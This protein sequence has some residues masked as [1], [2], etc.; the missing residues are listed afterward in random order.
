MIKEG[1]IGLQEAV[2][3]VTITSAT[4]LF[5]TSPSFLVRLV[6]TSA[7]YVTIISALTGMLGFTFIYFLLKRFP[8][9]DIV[10]AFEL[11]LG[12]FFGFILSL[13]LA[14]FLMFYGAILLR[15]FI[16]VLK[17]YTLPLSQPS[18]IISIFLIVTVPVCYLGLETLAR[19]S[20]LVA[21]ILLISLLAILVLLVNKYNFGYLFPLW[22]YGIDKAVI[23][24]LKRSSGY[25]EV[26]LF[27]VIASS[28]HGTRE[29]KKAG[30]IMLLLSLLIVSSSFLAFTVTFPYFVAE[31]MTSPVYEMVRLI[32]Y[33]G[34]V[35]RLDPIFLFL[36]N[37]STLI[38]VTTLFYCSLSVYC[39]AFRLQDMR[40]SIIPGSAILFATAMIPDDLAGITQGY[41]QSFR[42]Y[43]WVI[44]YLL[45][46][47]VL[48]VAV[49]RKK[50][51]VKENA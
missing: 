39:K 43:G 4:K 48:I 6:G 18:F 22:G 47:S 35:Q 12:R 21:Y 3:L 44:F 16:E 49:L 14:V 50:K 1:K 11:S 2:C 7:W 28:M 51:G 32:N 23:T 10:G 36:W 25:G 19:F 27:A 42:E 46:L 33:G 17:V 45:P 38:S 40:P 30:Y 26:I 20:K 24:G 5:F 34:F 15:E 29:I 41:V 9:K 31:E 37:I 13:V 8:G